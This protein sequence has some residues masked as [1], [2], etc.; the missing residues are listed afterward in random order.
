MAIVV[1]M[2]SRRIVGWSM[3]DDITSAFMVDALQMGTTR[4]SPKPGCIAHSDRG[5]QYTSVIYGQALTSAGLEAPMGKCGCA[6]DNAACESVTS[7]IKTEIGTIN[8]GRPHSGQR[9]ATL[10]VF[11]F[12]EAFYNSLRLHSALG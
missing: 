8:S 9:A 10:E 12:I 2:W 5:A 7:T 1:D 11:D 4:R 3:R 6:Y